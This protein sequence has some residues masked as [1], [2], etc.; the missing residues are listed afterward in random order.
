LPL[1]TQLLVRLQGLPNL[2]RLNVETWDADMPDH[3]GRRED[4]FLPTLT[5]FS[6]AGSMALLEALLARL[7]APSLQE[8]R[9]SV[10]PR[11]ISPPTHLTSFIRKSGRQFFSAQVNAPGREINL[12]MSTYSHST[13]GPP[14]KI[15]AS[16]MRS[17]QMMGD[18]FSE[19][20]AT[21]EDVFLASPFCLENLAS[22]VQETFHSNTFFTP[23]CSA[24]IIRVSPGIES[25]VGDMFWHRAI[26]PD[27][28]PALEEIE[29]NSTT[30]SCTPIQNDEVVSVLELFQPF[31][32]ARQ[33][34]R[35]PVKVH[36]N[37]DRVLPEYFCNTEM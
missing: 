11:A 8:L 4:V 31:V 5:H 30:T 27:F 34:A 6:F 1:D 22:P 32:D 20:L 19:S 15:I 21:V 23:F 10:Y 25:E 7:T 13:D 16:R 29:L 35:Y 24:K 37:I 18:L 12:V 2:R 14:F 36:W 9:I 26:S 28:L 17:I 33:L 3:P